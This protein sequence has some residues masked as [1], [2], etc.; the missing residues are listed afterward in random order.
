MLAPPDR[1]TAAVQ[2]IQ[3]GTPP[4]KPFGNLPS[5]SPFCEVCKRAVAYSEAKH[6]AE[7]RPGGKFEV[8]DLPDYEKRLRRAVEAYQKLGL[9]CGYYPKEAP[10]A[11]RLAASDLS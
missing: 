10:R 8:V 5:A 7:E 9:R 11:N 2:F 6:R 3:L 1:H 4:P